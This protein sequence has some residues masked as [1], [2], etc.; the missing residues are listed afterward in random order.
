[1]IECFYIHNY[2]Y[3]LNDFSNASDFYCC[4]KIKFKNHDKENKNH[5][6]RRKSLEENNI[7]RGVFFWVALL[8]SLVWAETDLVYPVQ[9]C[10]PSLFI[11]LHVSW[12]QLSNRKYYYKVKRFISLWIW[13]IAFTILCG[14]ISILYLLSQYIQ[15]QTWWKKIDFFAFRDFLFFHTLCYFIYKISCIVFYHNIFKT[16]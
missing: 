15:I 10:L 4:W 6:E 3:Y 9:I 7:Y 5:I 16:V 1:M 11:L 8:F 14:I 2:Y 12:L 13:Q